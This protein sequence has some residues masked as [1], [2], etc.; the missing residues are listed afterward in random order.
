MK[1]EKKI[2]WNTV[3]HKRILCSPFRNIS[4]FISIEHS[5]LWCRIS[6]IG[7]KKVLSNTSFIYVQCTYRNRYNTK[8]IWKKKKCFRCANVSNFVLFQFFDGRFPHTEAN[9]IW[10]VPHSIGASLFILFFPFLIINM[11]LFMIT[12]FIP[13]PKSWHNRPREIRCVKSNRKK[14]QKEK[15]D[16]NWQSDR[17]DLHFGKILTHN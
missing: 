8:S 17:I 16:W 11:A 1:L 13:E 9:K 5:F 14:N 6:N 4:Y 15:R 10:I 2:H 3:K 12:H 7:C